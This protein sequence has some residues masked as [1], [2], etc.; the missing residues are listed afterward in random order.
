M[1]RRVAW[2]CALLIAGAGWSREIPPPPPGDDYIFDEAGLLHRQDQASVHIAQIE[3]LRQYNSP[4]V[5]VTISSASEYGAANVDELA[6]RWFNQWNIGTL[7]LERG[8]NQGML[9]LVAVADR[10]ARIELGADWGHD[11]DEHAKR[12]M[13]G[14]IVPRFKAGDYSGGVAAGVQGMLE[15]AKTGP[16]SQP[17]GDFLT[18][19]VQPLTKYS[20]LPPL[21]FLAVMGFG[22]VL[23]LLGIFP[24]FNKWLFFTGIGLILFGAFTYVVFALLLVAFGPRGSRSG[25]SGG[26]GGY[27]G[28]FSGGGGASGSW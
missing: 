17:P 10:R 19:R 22:M 28:G 13:D 25:S 7:G 9:L 15:M 14:K 6:T 1:A 11:W 12:I 5:V 21:P 3:A 27:S 26:G 2:L 8:A 24:R 23:T 4:I 20:L 16:H 18:R